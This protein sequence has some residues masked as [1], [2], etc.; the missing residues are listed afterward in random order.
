MAEDA[1]LARS[2]VTVV[3]TIQLKKGSYQIT[4]VVVGNDYVAIAPI[5]VQKE[6]SIIVPDEESTIGI[7]VGIGPMVPKDICATFMIGNTVKFNPKQFICTLDGLYPRY[8]NARII[9]TRFH[10]I[11]AAVPSEPVCVVGVD[12][13]KE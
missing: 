8:G 12:K 13:A 10:N 9:L 1:L 3:E 6:H 5:G 2:F 11:L 7:I 4:P